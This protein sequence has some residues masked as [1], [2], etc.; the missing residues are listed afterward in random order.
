MQAATGTTLG[1]SDSMQHKMYC[2]PRGGCAPK[3]KLACALLVT[4]LLITA[5]QSANGTAQGER[6]N[7]V[8][9]G[10]KVNVVAEVG[11]R[12]TDIAVD[13]GDAVTLG[14]PIVTL[15]DAALQAQAK[16]AQAAVMR[17]RPTWR[18]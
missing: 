6:F 18:K 4:S 12:I 16:Q 10:T 3:R 5:C 9:E 15:D 1:N 13:E 11:G 17:P 2:V 14:Q 7:G 8:L